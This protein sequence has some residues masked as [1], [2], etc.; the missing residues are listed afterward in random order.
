M[1]TIGSIK[2]YVLETCWILTGRTFNS[3]TYLVS[4]KPRIFKYE[5]GR[6]HT[7]SKTLQKKCQ[8]FAKVFLIM[9]NSVY[10]FH[11]NTGTIKKIVQQRV[12]NAT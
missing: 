2:K 10:I 12:N 5:E 9:F 6:Y 11:K 8:G 1:F 4:V 3:D 7:I